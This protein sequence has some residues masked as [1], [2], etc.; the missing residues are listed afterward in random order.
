MDSAQHR[1]YF[2]LREVSGS[3]PGSVGVIFFSFMDAVCFKS[4]KEEKKTLL[5]PNLCITKI[6]SLPFAIYKC[7]VR[8]RR[9]ASLES[10][11]S[12]FCKPRYKPRFIT[13]LFGVLL[14]RPS[15]FHSLTDDSSTDSAKI[16]GLF[17]HKRPF[18]LASRLESA[19][20]V[21]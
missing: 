20:S 19:P 12:L 9:F 11:V 18:L 13:A 5:I 3:S 4:S 14:L 16:S 1:A 6:Y 2:Y 10:I 15:N 21:T 17:S 8:Y 7:S